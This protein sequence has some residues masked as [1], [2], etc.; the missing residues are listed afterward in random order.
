MHTIQEVAQQ[1]NLT[2]DALRYYEK[3][4]LLVNIQRDK[5]GRRVYSD[6]DLAELNRLVHLRQL[7][8]SV[9]DT[10][11]MLARFNDPH[12]SL[13]SYD[14]GI[15][16]LEQLDA[17]LDQKIAAIEQQKLFLS[18][19]ITRFKNERSQLSATPNQ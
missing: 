15:E 14:A 18:H 10:K 13:E 2:Y 8:A 12:K 4:G 9:A 11:T 5:N 17:Q 7:G 6:D 3:A 16:F 1:F 19:K